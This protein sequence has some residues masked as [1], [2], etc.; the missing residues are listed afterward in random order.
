[1]E[2]S[3]IDAKRS[4]LRARMK[5]YIDAPSY[6]AATEACPN[7]ATK[8]ARYNPEDVWKKLNTAGG[9]SATK[10]KP[11]LTFPLDQ[12]WIYYESRQQMAQRSSTRVQRKS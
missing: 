5:A 8:R 3:V 9:F 6:E 11:F 12:R 7:V 10:I 4:G 1:M 2:D